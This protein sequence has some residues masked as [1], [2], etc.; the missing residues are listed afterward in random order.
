MKSTLKLAA[1]ALAL[2]GILVHAG[3]AQ[4]APAGL[5]AGSF[6]FNRA[7]DTRNVSGNGAAG[8][9]TSA[10]NG[11]QHG[12]NGVLLVTHDVAGGSPYFQ[13]PRSAVA[14]QGGPEPVDASSGHASETENLALM[15]AGLGLMGFIAR[16]RMKQE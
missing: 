3:N 11:I 13:P 9:N 6:S 2:A 5:S 8:V 16:R 1:V 10:G 14:T 4:S 12:N 7:A 15:L